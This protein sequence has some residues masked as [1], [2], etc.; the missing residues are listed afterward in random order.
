LKLDNVE[1]WAN[2]MIRY[3]PWSGVLISVSLLLTH[4]SRT[5]T[6]DRCPNNGIMG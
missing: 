5:V 4:L 3:L 1:Y 2:M 6:N